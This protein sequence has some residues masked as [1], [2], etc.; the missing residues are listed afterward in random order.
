MA[1]VTAVAVTAAAGVVVMAEA[2]AIPVTVEA[3]GIPATAAGAVPVGTVVAGASMEVSIGMGAGG[4]MASA[5]AG[6][7][8]PITPAGSGPA[9]SREAGEGLVASSSRSLILIMSPT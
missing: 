8:T 7:G 2:G 3:W 6:S 1:A 5:H 9:I 4:L